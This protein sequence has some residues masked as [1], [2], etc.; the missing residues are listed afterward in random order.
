M[1]EGELDGHLDYERHLRSKDGNSRNG[2]SKKKV[3]T[4]FWESEI[5]VPMDS[6]LIGMSN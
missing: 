5:S 3:R 4:S 2:H 1:L 6:P